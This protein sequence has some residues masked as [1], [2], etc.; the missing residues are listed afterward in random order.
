MKSGFRF[1]ISPVGW[2]WLLRIRT[3]QE[4][5]TA[6]L[7]IHLYVMLDGARLGRQ[8]MKQPDLSQVAVVAHRRWIYE[9]RRPLLVRCNY[10]PRRQDRHGQ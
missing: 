10:F 8:A 7:A 9:K 4:P 5:H 1:Q 6:L 2:Q 3:V